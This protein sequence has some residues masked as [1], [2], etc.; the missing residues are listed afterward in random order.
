[1]AMNKKLTNTKGFPLV[2]MIFAF[3]FS[4]CGAVQ[5]F[6]MQFVYDKA[7]SG[8]DKVNYVLLDGKNYFDVYQNAVTMFLFTFFAMF[9]LI[10]GVGRRTT[11]TKEGAL[12]LFTGISTA[13]MP[14]IN[15]VRFFLNGGLKNLNS[16]GEMFRAVNQ[17]VNIGLPA[18]VSLFVILSGLGIL[19]KAGASKTTVEVFKNAPKSVS[20]VAM[21]Q[22]IPQPQQVIPQPVAEPVME[23]AVIPA[24]APV[25]EEEPVVE[26]VAETVVEPVIEEPKAK[27]C[28]NC[29]T[30]ANEGAKF[31]RSC[32]TP[33]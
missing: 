14:S 2:M 28:P 30:E 13:V 32:G 8:A 16:D 12:L 22:E 6:A 11:G 19:I 20:P 27:T 24:V 1:M 18:V 3:L 29:G 9:V 26:P 31:C 25:I 17:A 7:F 4:A 21:P 10:A 33:L 15:T 23:E 5:E